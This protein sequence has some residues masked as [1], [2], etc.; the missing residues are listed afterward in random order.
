MRHPHNYEA[1]EHNLA[2]PH[3]GDFPIQ[4]RQST[5]SDAY[6]AFNEITSANDVRSVQ[7]SM[8]TNK[9]PIPDSPRNDHDL[10]CATT[11][12]PLIQNNIGGPLDERLLN[13]E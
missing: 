3:F 8:N 13:V 12:P 10:I 4:V 7:N 6:D 9:S 5:W 2:S 11:W 1:T